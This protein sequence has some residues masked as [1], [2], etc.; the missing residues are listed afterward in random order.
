MNNTFIR[1]LI[2]IAFIGAFQ[3]DADAATLNHSQST[4]TI[5]S[6]PCN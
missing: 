2:A 1:A 6:V 3:A 4:S 5:N